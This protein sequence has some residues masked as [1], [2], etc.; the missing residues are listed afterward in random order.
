MEIINRKTIIEYDLKE[1]KKRNIENLEELYDKN[2][3]MF[4]EDVI[5][6]GFKVQEQEEKKSKCNIY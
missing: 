3:P 6:S 5:E 4:I 1:G 2:K